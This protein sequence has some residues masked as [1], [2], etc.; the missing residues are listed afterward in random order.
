[1]PGRRPE[2]VAGHSVRD[3]RGLEKN[4]NKVEIYKDD[5][6]KWCVEV[7]GADLAAAIVDG[8]LAVSFEPGGAPP[9]VH[10]TLRADRL[11]MRLPEAVIDAI[12]QLDPATELTAPC[13]G[14]CGDVSPHD[15][16]LVPG[17]L[18]YLGRDA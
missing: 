16:H 6:G 2:P 1:M 7:N 9:R 11:N 18:E 5:K 12:K 3:V 4:V 14:E 13:H 15:A 10:M 17:A 8:G